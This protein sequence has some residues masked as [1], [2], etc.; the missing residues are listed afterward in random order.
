MDL[1]G[2]EKILTE[3]ETQNVSKTEI[4]YCP[5]E[6]LY[7]VLWPR[8]AENTEISGTC[9]N[10]DYVKGCDDLKRKCLS[11]GEWEE[12]SKYCHEEKSI[13]WALIGLFVFIIFFI[14][15]LHFITYNGI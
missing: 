1:Y 5:E 4:S 6:V 10:P 8:T 14:L 7:E 11:G 2:N 13:V 3:D 9:N 15:L 12:T